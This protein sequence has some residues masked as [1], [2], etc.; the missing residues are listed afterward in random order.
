MAERIES[1]NNASNPPNIPQSGILAG[2]LNGE[3]ERSGYICITKLIKHIMS[4]SNKV[5]HGTQEENQFLIFHDH[6][7]T[8][9]EKEAQKYLEAKEYRPRLVRANGN[10][11]QEFP[12]CFELSVTADSSEICRGLDC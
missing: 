9:Y 3:L 11:N 4:K 6:L 1:N 2:E 8:F 5:Y 7:S 10:V 12:L